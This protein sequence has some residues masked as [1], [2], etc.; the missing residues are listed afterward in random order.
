MTLLFQPEI[1][2]VINKLHIILHN[3]S[4]SRHF[5]V[6]RTESKILAGKCYN[7]SNLCSLWQ[8]SSKCQKHKMFLVFVFVFRLEHVQEGQE[9]VVPEQD[10]MGQGKLYVFIK[11]Y[12]VKKYF[13]TFPTKIFRFFS[14]FLF[15]K[16]FLQLSTIF[17]LFQLSTILRLLEIRKF[18]FATKLLIA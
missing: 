5:K 9:V 17:W 7:G 15:S 11:F 13:S 6:L 2:M 8:L 1:K 12:W 4:I 3:L 16:F 10:L 14:F 18:Y